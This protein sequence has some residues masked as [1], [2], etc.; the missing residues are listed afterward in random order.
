[1]VF[2][3]HTLGRLTSYDGC[4]RQHAVLE[5]DA[6]GSKNSFHDGSP[7]LFP[8]PAGPALGREVPQE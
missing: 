3:N 8:V 4:S 5:E 6:N 2:Q 1:M 7:V